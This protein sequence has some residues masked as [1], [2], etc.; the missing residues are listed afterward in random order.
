MT[1]RRAGPLSCGSS[2][3]CLPRRPGL[4]SEY[5]RHP[6]RQIVL[7]G[8]GVDLGDMQPEGLLLGRRGQPHG[9]AKCTGRP[10]AVA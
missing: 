5:F 8:S 10:I 6:F 3:G 9:K 2:A 4:Q 7:G 1:T